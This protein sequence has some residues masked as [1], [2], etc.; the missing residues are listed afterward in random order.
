MEATTGKFW[1]WLAC[2]GGCLALALCATAGA[3][4]PLPKEVTINGVEFVL[5][6]AGD[7]YK[8]GGQP[9][10]GTE[11]GRMDEFGGGNVKVWLDDYYIAKYE[12]RARHLVD[13]LNS[14][15]G[16]R[17]S[18]IG[19]FISCSVRRGRDGKYIPF[20]PNEDHPA[21]HLSWDMADRWARWMGFRLPTEAEWE[22]AARGADERIYPWG[23]AWPDETYA[24][25]NTHSNCFTWPIDMFKKGVS[26]YGVYNMAGNVREYVADWYNL[27]YDRG[28]SDGM[29]NPMPTAPGPL[30]PVDDGPLKMLKGGRWGSDPGQ[31]RIGARIYFM[32]HIAFRCNGARF[33]LDVA[34]VR[35]HL[36]K[37]TATVTKQ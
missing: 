23:D 17:E 27:D 20:L 11:F 15:A 29:R 9:D 37:G 3:T 26:P 1:K 32:P 5:I 25:F 7:F 8:T 2:A 35:E 33:G 18:Y 14:T 12:A 21:T 6:P 13:Y 31:L 16:A 22:K 19:D 36:A 4:T 28:L 30:D 10:P 34:T 24:G